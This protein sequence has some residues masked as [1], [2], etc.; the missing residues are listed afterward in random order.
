MPAE[1]HARTRLLSH[2]ELLTNCLGVKA[3]QYKLSKAPALAYGIQ[4]VLVSEQAHPHYQIIS[5]KCKERS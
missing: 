2:C 1:N 3:E 4:I 5:L